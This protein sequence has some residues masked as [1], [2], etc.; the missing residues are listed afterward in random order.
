MKK[1]KLTHQGPPR[2][3]K[4]SKNGEA[5][6]QNGRTLQALISAKN[7]RLKKLIQ[8]WLDDESGYDEET[9][10]WLKTALEEDRLSARRL[11]RD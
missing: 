1:T 2:R 11:F 10:P 4:P 6:P 9:W 3:Q 8:S 7:R 5:V